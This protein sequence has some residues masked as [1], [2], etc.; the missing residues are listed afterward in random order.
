MRNN[1]L[2]SDAEETRG[3]GMSVFMVDIIA[4]SGARQVYI[5]DRGQSYEDI[6]GSD[7]M[8]VDCST[9]IPGG[10]WII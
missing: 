9:P 8:Y 1:E 6:C 5:L 10:I 2:P 4:K 3:S 7:Y